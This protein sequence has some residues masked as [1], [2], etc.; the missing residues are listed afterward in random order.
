MKQKSADD[1]QT[2]FFILFFAVRQLL[3]YCES[4]F[5]LESLF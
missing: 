3:F 2:L 5:V 4:K 1:P